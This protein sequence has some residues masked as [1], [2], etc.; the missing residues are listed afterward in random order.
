MPILYL[1]CTKHGNN[2][3]ISINIS[4]WINFLSDKLYY[5]I[6]KCAKYK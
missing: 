4:I 3:D 5:Y 6:A 2:F 1:C